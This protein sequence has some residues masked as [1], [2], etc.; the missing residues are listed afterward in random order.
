M[1][2]TMKIRNKVTF[3]NYFFA[4][5]QYVY[6]PVIPR[7]IL[8]IVFTLL[9]SS[10]S[11]MAQKYKSS[12]GMIKFYSEELLEDI[13]AINK[14]VNSVFDSESGQI[15]FSIPMS[16]FDFE[17]SLMQ[18]HFNEKYI[19]SDKLPKSTFKGRITGYEVD[20]RNPNIWAEGE[21][22]IHGV[23][24]NIKAPG[25][26]DFVDGKVL[27][28]SVF[29]V[30]LVDYNIKVPK[31]MFQKIAEEIEITINIEYKPYEK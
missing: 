7:I 11:I 23:K 10:T 30:K 5:G 27:I 25:S 31:L 2:K 24:Q 14:K 9:L 17:K 18:E 8:T 21:L 4:N 22:E 20:R 12:D 1:Y 19:E 28:H 16:G 15:V 26:L 3:I 29:I 6:R 13:T